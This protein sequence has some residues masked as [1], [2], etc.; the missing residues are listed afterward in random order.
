MTTAPYIAGDGTTRQ[1]SLAAG[2][3]SSGNPD[4]ANF[5][6]TYTND[7]PITGATVPTGGAGILG[8]LSAIFKLIPIGQTTK[9]ASVSV[10][11]ASDQTAIPVSASFATAQLP[12]SLGQTTEANSLSVTI[13]SNQTVP[14]SNTQL[15]TNLG[16]TTKASSL[17]VAIA[18]DNTVAISASALPLPSGASQD[19]TDAT[20]V[21]APSGAVGIRGWLSGVYSLVS[22]LYS[23]FSR[24]SITYISGTVST[25]G[26]NTVIAAPSSGSIWLTHLSIQNEAT[27]A[28]TILLQDSTTRLRVLG[29]NQGNGIALVFPQGREF[30]LAATTALILNLSAANQVGYSIG[31]YVA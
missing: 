6:L 28:T 24:P 7:S 30:K 26:S 22:S 21:S 20:G 5:A 14:T 15:P 8:L 13:A 16:Q 23:I 31:Y 17:S 2:D 27:T 9:S 12:T 19:G 10:T 4:I 25:S 18:S 1:R 11:I 29:E 3:G